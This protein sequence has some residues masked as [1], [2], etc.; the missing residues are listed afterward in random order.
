MFRPVAAGQQRSQSI[1]PEGGVVFET[2]GL[3]AARASSEWRQDSRA[4]RYA[5]RET[6]PAARSDCL[7]RQSIH[8]LEHIRIGAGDAL[9]SIN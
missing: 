4:S 8:V 3:I 2:G 1:H 9:E 5:R 6:A 7:R